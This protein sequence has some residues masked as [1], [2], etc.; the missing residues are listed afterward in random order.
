MR[1]EIKKRT[2]KNIP[3]QVTWKKHGNVKCFK[4]K[5]VSDSSALDDLRYSQQ[6]TNKKW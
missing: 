1:T 2:A 6:T 3:E 4:S 5:V